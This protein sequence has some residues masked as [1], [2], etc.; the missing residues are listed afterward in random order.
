M[1]V[2]GLHIAQQRVDAE[3]AQLQAQLELQAG[4]SGPV[5]VTLDV[6]GPDGQNVGQFTQD[7]VVDPGQNRIALAVRIAKPKRWFP[8]GYGAQDRY[9]FV[10][11]VRDAD[12]DS[13]QIKRVT[14]LRSVELRREKT[15]SARAWRS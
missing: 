1:R 5:Q 8:A 6:L 7:A 3:S 9:T 12:G 14:G 13:Q 15:R 10:A 4:R 11:S 2:D